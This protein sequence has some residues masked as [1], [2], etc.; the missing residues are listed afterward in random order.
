MPRTALSIFKSCSEKVT[1]FPTQRLF[2]AIADVEQH[3][4]Q[5]VAYAH[6][7]SVMGKHFRFEEDM[8][9]EAQFA[10]LATHKGIHEDFEATLRASQVPISSEKVTGAKQWLVDHI[11]LVDFK[12]KGKLH[13]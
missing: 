8:M 13:G 1:L 10:D 5:A 2:K 3:P 4:S 9:K 7:K 11:K 12:Y 6:L